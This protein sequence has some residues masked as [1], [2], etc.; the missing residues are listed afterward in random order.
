MTYNHAFAIAFSIGGST[1]EDGSEITV[2]QFRKAIEDRMDNLDEVGD[3][4]WQEAIGAP[5]DSYED[6][7]ETSHVGLAKHVVNQM[8]Y[9]ELHES[10]IAGLTQF[11]ENDPDKFREDLESEGLN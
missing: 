8:D 4:E 1:T 6:T 3:L 2:E 11:Y 10:A 9:A 5:H 7:P